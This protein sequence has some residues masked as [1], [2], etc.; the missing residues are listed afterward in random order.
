M[1]FFNI[2]LITFTIRYI[3]LFYSF[4]LTLSFFFLLLVIPFPLFLLIPLILLLLLNFL[5][6]FFWFLSLFSRIFL[7]MRQSL[8]AAVIELNEEI[9]NVHAPICEQ[10]QV[11]NLTLFRVIYFVSVVI[12]CVLY[13]CCY[14]G[15]DNYYHFF[16]LTLI[17]VFYFVFLFSQIF[18]TNPQLSLI[19]FNLFIQCVHFLGTHSQWRVRTCVRTFLHSW[20][21]SKSSCEEK[22]IPSTYFNKK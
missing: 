5:L 20:I 1:F 11:F 21:I 12:M 10:A 6:S 15:N 13:C 3:F 19:I 14:Y 17:F 2:T 8:M 18:I 22:K 4:H 9:D 7:D 16:H